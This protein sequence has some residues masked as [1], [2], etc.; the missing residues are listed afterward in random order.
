MPGNEPPIDGGMVGGP[1][2]VRNPWSR[3]PEGEIEPAIRKICL[4]YL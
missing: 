4:S 1:G 2:G 3:D